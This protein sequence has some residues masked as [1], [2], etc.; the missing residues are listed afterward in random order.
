[1]NAPANPPG[2]GAPVSIGE[3]P[4][5]LPYQSA[6]TSRERSWQGVTVDVYRS[7]QARSARHAQRDHHMVL[8]CQSGSARLVQYR[9][10]SVHEGILSAGMSLVMPAGH[11]SLWEGE[12]PSTT[13]LRIPT[14]LVRNAADE[15]GPHPVSQLEIRNEFQTRD[16]IFERISLIFLAELGQAPH[17]AQRVLTDALSN[18]IAAHLAG[19]YNLFLRAEPQDGALLSP[20][21]LAK[22]TTYVE[23]HLEQQITLAELAMVTGVSRFHF[24]RLFRQSTGM[25]AMAFVEQSRIRRAQTLISESRLPL[26]EV[27][28]MAGF[29]DQSHFT[30]RFSRHVGCTPGAYARSQ[31]RRRSSRQH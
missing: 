31:G 20:G 28:L 11:D 9:A 16:A 24:A 13:R 1:M 7:L 23:D 18:A 17:P 26:A 3:I 21:E 15:M 5:A 14:Q 10:G 29:A 25:S 6:L 8:F 19:R 30:R 27:A 12:A 22:L 2:Q 4:R